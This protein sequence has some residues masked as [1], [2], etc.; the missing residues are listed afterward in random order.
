[1]GL[2]G[3]VHFLQKKRHMNSDI[4]VNQVL[5]KLG[6]PFYERCIEEKSHM[7]W[8]NDGAGYHTSKTTTKWRQQMGLICIDW[9]AQ[10]LDLNPIK[11]LWRIIKIRVSAHCHQIHSVDEMK[12]VI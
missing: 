3:P 11:N 9:P 10:S 5:K 6:L 7:I 1:M 2:K 8:I 4:Y 12:L